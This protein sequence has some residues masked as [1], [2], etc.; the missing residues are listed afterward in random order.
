MDNKRINRKDWTRYLQTF[1]KDKTKKVK[2]I[3]F[4]LKASDFVGDLN[5]ADLQ[6]QSGNQVSVQVPHTSEMLKEKKH[7]IDEYAFLETVNGWKKKGVQPVAKGFY[8]GMKNRVFNIVGRGHEVVAL[9]NVFHEDYKKE[10]LTSGLDLELYAKDDF[11]LLRISTNDGAYVEGR[12]YEQEVLQSNPL[13]RKYTREFYFEGGKAGEKITLST[14]LIRADVGGRNMPIG[15]R[16]I[17]INGGKMKLSRQRLMV[18]PFGSF[19]LRIEFYKQVTEGVYN[20]KTGETEV[21]T[22]MKDVGIGY[23]G[24]AQFGQVE[25]HRR[26]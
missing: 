8:S 22:Y 3:S 12:K 10:L 4:D 15:Q 14:T 16:E 18:S 9:P 25:G 24:T 6:L 19:R 7:S 21:L 13:N 2:S 17:Y 1:S 23:Y 26:F 11:D 5:V 20:E